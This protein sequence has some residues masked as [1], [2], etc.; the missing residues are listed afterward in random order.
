MLFLENQDSSVVCSDTTIIL[1]TMNLLC[2]KEFPFARDY[3][4]PPIV[5]KVYE[6]IG[7]NSPCNCTRYNIGLQRKV[8]YN[9]NTYCVTCK[10]Q[11]T[12]DIVWIQEHSPNFE[13][14]TEEEVL[15]NLI[16]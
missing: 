15:I 16:I 3:I 14:L 2:I 10:Q 6:V 13:I 7:T 8:P 11:V 9:H 12:G 4:N 5:G 1:T